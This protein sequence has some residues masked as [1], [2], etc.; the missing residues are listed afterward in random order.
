MA[1][2]RSHD[3]RARSRPRADQCGHRARA[4][5]PT[6]RRRGGSD[7]CSTRIPSWSDLG[8][9]QPKEPCMIAGGREVGPSPPAFDIR[10]LRMRELMTLVAERTVARRE[11]G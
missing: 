6:R 3:V 2:C 7:L 1:L 9:A 5:D 8:V 10:E 4:G 11:I